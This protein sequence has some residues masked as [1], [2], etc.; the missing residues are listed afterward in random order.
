MKKILFYGMT[1]EKMC[2]QQKLIS[3]IESEP[4]YI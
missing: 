4:P 2:F 3:E 1:S